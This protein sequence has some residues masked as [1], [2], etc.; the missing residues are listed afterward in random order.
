MGKMSELFQYMT[1]PGG[2][3]LANFRGRL[4]KVVKAQEPSEVRDKYPPFNSPSIDKLI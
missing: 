2:V 3:A 4:F 1:L